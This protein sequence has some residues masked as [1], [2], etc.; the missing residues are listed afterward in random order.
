MHV[1]QWND[2]EAKLVARAARA[3]AD[4]FA[5]TRP[6]LRPAASH[7]QLQRNAL[8]VHRVEPRD[9]RVVRAA[10]TPQELTPA[11]GPRP[12]RAPPL[13]PPPP[14]AAA[15]L[16]FARRLQTP[17]SRPRGRAHAVRIESTETHEPVGPLEKRARARRRVSTREGRPDF[18]IGTHRVTAARVTLSTTAP[19][20]CPRVPAIGIADCVAIQNDSSRAPFRTPS[21]I[22]SP[23]RPAPVAESEEQHAFPFFTSFPRVAPALCWPCPTRLRQARVT[24]IGRLSIAVAVPGH[25]PLVR[26]AQVALLSGFLTSSNVLQ[27]LSAGRPVSASARI[28]YA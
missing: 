25:N 10:C 28:A 19:A 8:R 9:L 21:A 23:A 1:I 20:V 4:H 5:A 26:H 3:C 12:P 15:R 27:A 7:A 13:V 24:A 2:A 17:Q 22:R 18:A 16:P 11:T 6:R 14:F